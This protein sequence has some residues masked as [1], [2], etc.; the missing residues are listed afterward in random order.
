VTLS[1]LTKNRSGTAPISLRALV[2]ALGPSALDVLVAPAGLDVGVRGTAIFDA[3][4]PVPDGDD[5]ILLLVG[6]RAD[7][8]DIPHVVQ[9]AADH[10][11]VALVVKLRGCDSITVVD[12]ARQRGLTVLA[13]PDDVPWR[14]L[15]AL[16]VSVLGSG[17]LP[18][19]S[20]SGTGETLFALA[21]ALGAIIGGSV[22]IEDLAQHVL[23]YSSIEGQQIDPLRERGILDRRVPDYPHHRGQYLQVLQ[24]PGVTRFPPVGDELAR[25]AAAIRAGDMPLGTIWAIEGE[26]GL[27]PEGERAL[28]DGVKVA[29]LHMLREQDVGERERHL[30]GE[31]LRS[32]LA[33]TR[34]TEGGAERLGLS[35]G[36]GAALVGFT[37]ADS[38]P[39]GTLTARVGHA[40]SQYAA[41]YRPEVTITTTPQSV[42]ALVPG[43]G[44]GARRFA[45][46]AMA[47]AQ[48]ATG[49]KIQ[50]AMTPSSEDLDDLVSLRDE[51]DAVL[52]AALAVGRAPVVATVADVH[53][54]LL[55]DRVGDQLARD[56]RLRHPEVQ[57]MTDHDRTRGT[58]YAVTVLAWLESFNDIGAAAS[59]L[60]VHPNTL[61][62]R[63][64]RIEEKFG[65]DFTDAESRLSAWLQLRMVERR[66]P[67]EAGT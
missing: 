46:G 5:S 38:D 39:S 47:S 60:Q 24:S 23:A 52:G 19:G 13:T 62:Y 11:F 42:Y 33:G 10:G 26:G 45:D 59:R 8:P 15:D 55:L 32:M 17:G 18:N 34:T 65:L 16:L 53:T 61:R 67:A 58:D 21:N 48:K 35:P 51:V 41:A 56:P 14:R 27:T 64:R 50:A 9:A 22:A 57:R 29:A 44:D 43:T 6:I 2:D 31:V 3:V 28:L 66:P 54:R 7:S 20:V 63:L 12:A 36:S 4:D 30:R 49:T 37:T 25:A 40:V 1:D